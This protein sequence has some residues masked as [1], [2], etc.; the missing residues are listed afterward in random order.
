MIGFRREQTSLAS[1]M[2]LLSNLVVVRT[3]IDALVIGGGFGGTLTA[4]LLRRLGLR[5]VVVERGVHPRFAIGE[6]STPI[7]NLALE[8][9]SRTYNLPRLAPLASYGAWKRAY[10]ELTVGLK[11]GFSYFYHRAETPFEP[12]EDHANELL[13]AASAHDEDA[14][15]HWL[16]SEF[17]HFLAR[18][19]EAEGVEILDRTAIRSIERNPGGGFRLVADR[20]ASPL[21]LE[22][23]FLIDAAGE[24]GVLAGSLGIATAPTSLRTNS[25]AL[26]G[27]FRGLASYS[28]LLRNWGVRVEDHP[29]PCD[30]AAMHHVFDGGWMWVLPFENGVTSA[31]FVF[32]G[33]L[34]PLDASLAPDEEWRATMARFPSIAA[35]FTRAEI[36]APAGGLRRT[37]RLQ[38]RAAQTSGEDWAM[39]P[40]AAC[41]FDPLHSTGNAHTLLGIERLVSTLAGHWNRPTLG[42]A[43]REGDRA[44]DAEIATLDQVIHGSY[45]AMRCFDLF[46]DYVMFYFAA[47]MTS[48]NRRRAGETGDAYLRADDPAFRERLAA[49]HASLVA[50]D[51]QGPVSPTAAAEF[52]RQVT[53]SLSPWKLTGLL[54]PA[55]R[56]MVPFPGS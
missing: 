53:R 47:A 31:G 25:R 29:F 50:I 18:E 20:A 40:G 23:R 6:S 52:R 37:P 21:E 8:Q 12:R 5:V 11:R 3:M 14:D 46:V 34:S 49:T 51:A 24:A 44:L 10:P 32:D 2:G 7:V 9:L 45:R 41:F 36:V 26:F 15:T 30:A 33:D 1:E 19:A 22:A 27:H 54:E 48:E 38:R 55:K 43:L 16:R 39:L 42:G 4:L 56:N 17:D 13:V 28:E 35:Q